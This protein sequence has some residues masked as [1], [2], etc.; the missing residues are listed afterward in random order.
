M[1]GRFVLDSACKIMGYT[2]QAYYKSEGK[3]TNTA[4]SLIPMIT[5]VHAKRRL[6][7]TK[8]CRAIYES[9]GHKWPFGRDR[10]ID[11]MMHLGFAVKYPKRYGK[12]TRAGTREFENKLVNRQVTAINQVWQADMAYYIHG[13]RRYY[14]IYITDV[15]S[16]E[17]VGYGA[18]ETNHAA[19]YC[20]V[21]RNAVKKQ[22]DGRRELQNLIHHSDGGKQYESNLYKSLCKRHG[23]SQSMCMYSYE[24]P[25]AE[26]TND[27]INN[28]YLNVWKPRTLRELKNKQRLAVHDHNRNSR[29]KVLGKRTPLEFKEY[30]DEGNPQYI[31]NLK[32]INPEQPKNK[33]LTLTNYLTD[34]SVKT[35]NQI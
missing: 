4:R 35:V 18:F 29:K 34:I 31:L 3:K 7:P 16:Q 24:N 1:T 9:D 5:D 27:L 6:N 30:I 19:N 8:G 26:K 13:E 25:Y 2:R 11:L 12:S 32:P 10:S 21:L 28:G 33:Q 23:I 20:T 22:H 17:I 14:T 15:Y